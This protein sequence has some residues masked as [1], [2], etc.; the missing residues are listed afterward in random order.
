M[1][2]KRKKSKNKKLGLILVAEALVFVGL[3]LLIKLFEF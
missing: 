1:S 3:L 2:K